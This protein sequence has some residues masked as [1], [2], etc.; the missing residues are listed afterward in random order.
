[1]S[2]R[3]VLFQAESIESGPHW[4]P[5]PQ[6]SIPLKLWSEWANSRA[7]AGAGWVERRR[8]CRG[9]KSVSKQRPSKSHDPPYVCWVI[10]VEPRE[11]SPTKR[12]CSRC[13]NRMTKLFSIQ[14]IVRWDEPYS[15]WNHDFKK[16]WSWSFLERHRLSD[17]RNYIDISSGYPGIS[18]AVQI[19]LD[20]WPKIQLSG[21]DDHNSRDNT[22]TNVA[23]EKWKSEEHALLQIMYEFVSMTTRPCLP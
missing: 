5:S 11:G 18:N 21:H 14:K 17:A 10:G 1:M 19:D 2:H 8:T 13:C 20:E 12:R 9:I 16:L 6:M 7:A 4:V 22:W 15:L 23:C 3:I